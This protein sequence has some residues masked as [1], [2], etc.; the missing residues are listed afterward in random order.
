[1]TNYISLFLQLMNAPAWVLFSHVQGQGPQ[2]AALISTI[3]V[4]VDTVKC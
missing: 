3:L 4:D 2:T 1:M